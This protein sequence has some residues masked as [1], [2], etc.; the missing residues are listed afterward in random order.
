MVGTP[1][2]VQLSTSP[3]YG[4]RRWLGAAARQSSLAAYRHLGK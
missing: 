1:P 4:A 2:V 3:E